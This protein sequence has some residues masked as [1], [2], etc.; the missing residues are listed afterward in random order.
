MKATKKV[1]TKKILKGVTLELSVEEAVILYCILSRCNGGGPIYEMFSRLNDDVF[2]GKNDAPSI[3][4]NS[5][6]VEENF[7]TKIRQYID[8]MV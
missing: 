4:V 6:R 7:M 1:E 8:N 3:N 2:D 5:L